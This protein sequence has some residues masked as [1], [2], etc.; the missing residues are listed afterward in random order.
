MT[1]AGAMGLIGTVKARKVV[2]LFGPFW[3]VLAGSNR[4]ASREA[5]RYSRATA[6]GPSGDRALPQAKSSARKSIN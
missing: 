3:H 4:K 1:G 6:S 2:V 5:G